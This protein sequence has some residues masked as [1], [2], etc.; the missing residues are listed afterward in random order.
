[1]DAATVTAICA[2]LAGLAALGKLLVDRHLAALSRLEARAEANTAA[3]AQIAAALDAVREHLIDLRRGQERTARHVV[4]LLDH[5]GL[6]EHEPSLPTEPPP[7]I[8]RGRTITGAHPAVV[9][10]QR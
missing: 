2:A 3:Q 9:E 8:P 5:A 1:M 4:R 7:A 10:P 6:S